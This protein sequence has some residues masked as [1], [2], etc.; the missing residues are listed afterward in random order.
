MSLLRLDDKN[1]IAHAGKALKTLNARLARAKEA[2]IEQAESGTQGWLFLPD[3]REMVS[4]IKNLVAKTRGFSD[5]LVIGIG[6]SDLGARAL[7]KAL[8]TQKTKGL[9]L[10]FAGAN[11]DPDELTTI[12]RELDLK[13]T[14]VNVI[15]KSGDTVEPMATFLI[16]KEA[17]A[18]AVGKGNVGKHIVATTD[19]N[20]GSLRELAERESFYTLPVAGNIGGRF[21]VLTDVGLFPLA[22]AGIDI[23]ALLK[24]AR[25]ERD[26]FVRD[27]A[28]RYQ[29]A[30]YAALQYLMAE[31]YDRRIQI[32]MPYAER[33]REF[34]FWYRQLWAE[35]LGKRLNKKGKVV[36][37]GPTPIA[38]LGATDQHSQIQLYV[39]GPQDKTVTFIEV[40]HFDTDLRVPTAAKTIPSLAY[41]SGVS[42]QRVIHAERE[43]TARALTDAKRPNA[44]IHLDRISPESMGSLVMFFQ[45]VTGLSGELYDIDAYDQPGVEGGK[46]AMRK[47]LS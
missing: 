40:D 9:R 23:V 2:V 11:T 34:G 42:M 17:L 44:T 18:K 13:R 7:S 15:S 16:V 20:A 27:S 32:L 38:A 1:L 12:L 5:L 45:I 10:H 47:I 30:R 22:A 6:G 29:G 14:L 26:T 35:S 39:E 3:D 41:L 24:G 4:R 31:K 21:S 19:Q 36:H 8:T 28:D 46:R 37:V 33:L 25:V 43:A